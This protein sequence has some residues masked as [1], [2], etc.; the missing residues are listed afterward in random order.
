[1]LSCPPVSL[2]FTI[3]TIQ[4]IE[5][6]HIFF[7]YTQFFSSNNIVFTF[8]TFSPKN[9]FLYQSKPWNITILLLSHFILVHTISKIL[10]LPVEFAATK[11]DDCPRQQTED[12]NCEASSTSSSD[13]GSIVLNLYDKTGIGNALWYTKTCPVKHTKFTV[14][15]DK[16]D[17]QFFFCIFMK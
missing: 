16:W 8:P 6:Y 15:I 13:T 10:I 11:V 7:L 4:Q 12:M 2:G 17:Q 14:F 1:M 3:S 9:C 5:R